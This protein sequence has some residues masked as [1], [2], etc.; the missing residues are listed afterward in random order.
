MA[1][2]TLGSRFSSASDS[3]GLALWHVTNRW[4]SVMRSALAPHGLTH[5]QYVLLAT[6]VWHQAQRMDARLTQAE[7]A[8]LAATDV[9]MTSQ[10]LRALEAKG[11]VERTRHPHDGRA[12]ILR[13]TLDGI[14]A[15]QR[16]TVDVER[17]DAE[18]FAA[19][20]NPAAFQSELA[21]LSTDQGTP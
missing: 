6:L 16:A 10:V 20:A 12:R 15:A 4:Q 13:P 21:R 9:M 11:L 14:A 19:L 8:A 17:A 1:D 18:Y 5:V 7:L 2:V 3:P